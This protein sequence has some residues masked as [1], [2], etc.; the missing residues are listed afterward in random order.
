MENNPYLTKQ[1][2]TYLG[3]KRA[4]LGFIGSAVDQVCLKLKKDRSAYRPHGRSPLSINLKDSPYKRLPRRCSTGCCFSES[5]RNTVLLPESFRIPLRRAYIASLPYSSSDI[6]S[7]YFIHKHDK[8][9][10]SGLSIVNLGELPSCQTNE[11]LI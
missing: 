5:R 4:L 7:F 1:L 6:L 9:L 11:V 2:I 3:N 8:R 10:R